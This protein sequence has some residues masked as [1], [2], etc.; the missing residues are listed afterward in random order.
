[1]TRSEQ[2]APLWPFTLELL[3]SET[4]AKL[5]NHTEKEKEKFRKSAIKYGH[6][7]P[8]KRGLENTYDRSKKK[9][10]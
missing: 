7:E 1:M 3:S 2:A 10:S 4:L 5:A 9:V 6:K 8:K